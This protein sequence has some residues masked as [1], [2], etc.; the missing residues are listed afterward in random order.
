MAIL[1]R[2]V[3]NSFPEIY[4][5]GGNFITSAAPTNFHQFYKQKILTPAED[6]SDYR[7]VTASER[8][9]LEKSDAAWERPPQGFIDECETA[10]A[11]YNRST[12]FFELNGLTDLTYKSMRAV[13]HH[14]VVRA[15]SVKG[16]YAHK[17]IPS[18]VCRTLLATITYGSQE[19]Y[20]AMYQFC[21]GLETIR[22]EGG[23]GKDAEVG[24][25]NLYYFC[26]G[27]NALREV[28]G[29]F[30]LKT[31][32]VQTP[33]YGTPN[34]EG[35]YIKDLHGDLRMDAPKWRLDCI[36]YAVANATNTSPITITLHPDAYARLTDEL[37]IAA[38][39]KQIT[40]AST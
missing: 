29:V 23:Y 19:D 25:S 7:E 2:I 17:S 18:S 20:S 14:S 5:E 9:A 39:E 8:T 16:L 28:Y 11:V 32:N 37:I 15:N 36:E 24:V 12:G 21:R 4:V 10:G 30:S 34:L 27:C 6:I 1:S 40:F 22:I 38:A 33:T 31:A 13:M 26:G 35:F 3:N